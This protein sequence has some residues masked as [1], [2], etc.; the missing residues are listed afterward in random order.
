MIRRRL[1]NLDVLETPVPAAARQL[2]R[3]GH[4]H[5]PGVLDGSALAALAAEVAEVFAAS[6]P[7]RAH[8]GHGEWRH[9]MLN[10]SALAQAAIGA[11]AILEVIEPLL[12]SDCHIIANTAWR[13]R[14]GHG[15][16]PWHTDAGPHVPRPEGVPWPDAIAYPVFAI[17]MHLFLEDCPRAAGP[18]AVVPGSH[19]SG[20]PVPRGRELDP[21]LSWDGRPPVL[22]EAR[23]GDAI[24]FVSDAWHRGTPAQ[25]GHGRFFLQAHYGRRDIAQRIATT[26][27]VNHLTPEAV[28]RAVTPRARTLAGLHEPFFYDA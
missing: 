18:T 1:G 5:L 6:A 17:G 2:E 12:G 9:G 20:R 26:A 22:L 23:A 16:G 10:R 4:A 28:A 3:D 8:D 7:D 15:G 27:E 19:R 13:N 24:L 11:P 21:V 14:Q 25:P